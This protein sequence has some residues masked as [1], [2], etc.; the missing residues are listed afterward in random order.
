MA[1]PPKNQAPDLTKAIDITTG[2]IERLVCPLGKPQAFLRD[3]KA[4]GL[5]VR[6][7][8]NG[9]KS[10]VFEA[11]LDRQTIRRTIGDVRAWKIDQAR[12]EANRFRVLIDNGE[13]PR[14]HDKIQ[15][16]A[17]IER[18]IE[19]ERSKTTVGEAW[20][21]YLAARK[22]HWGTRH[23]E[24]HKRL[25]KEGGTPAKRGTRGTG[26]TKPGPIYALLAMRLD[27]L[28]P[29]IIEAWA[30]EQ[31]KERPTYGRL[32][33]RCLK[34]FLAWCAEDREYKSLVDAGAAKTRKSR[35]AFGKAGQKK[36]VLL[37]EQL[38]AWFAAVRGLPNATVAAYLQTLLL[39]G[40]RRGELLELKWT[41]TDTK[42]NG[43]TI[44][45][46]VEG[47][48]QI[49]LTPYVWSL[50]DALPRINQFV[51]ASTRKKDQA[52][53]DPNSAMETVCITAGVQGL[54]LHGL[55]RSFKSLTE[56]LEIPA[57]VVAQIMGHKPSATAEKHYTV[58]PLD[59][60]RIHHE[61]IEAWML[62][63]A[64]VPFKRPDAVAPA[65]AEKAKE[66]TLGTDKTDKRPSSQKD[67]GVKPVL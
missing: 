1:R 28:T 63:Q 27:E 48:R 51:F 41:D 4:P 14:E 65:P 29:P 60:I 42:W 7:T 66:P 45:D 59:L 31:G 13:D 26:K 10:F 53:S 24:D 57:G 8:A 9:A 67:P 16:A 35:D 62:E 3:L 12:V 30:V 61:R 40:S 15:T 49:P 6:V 50:L 11:K 52:L 33:W 47:D 36:D 5:R 55:R 25:A 64:K 20:I 18:N 39:I 34:A 54:T 37:K 44:R 22:E 58:R 23:Y 43:M 32:A 2:S 56:W 21:A 38:P 46:K 19:A 17:K